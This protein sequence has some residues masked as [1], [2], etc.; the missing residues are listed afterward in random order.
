[1]RI[2]YRWPDI[3]TCALVCAVSAALPLAFLIL[4]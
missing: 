2:R 1:M 3:A 4:A